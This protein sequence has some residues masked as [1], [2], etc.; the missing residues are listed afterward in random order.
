ML[1]NGCRGTF[2]PGLPAGEPQVAEL[3]HRSRNAAAA[4]CLKRD[5]ARR[6]RAPTPR[7]SATLADERGVRGALGFLVPGGADDG[8]A[9]TTPLRPARCLI[10]TS[11]ASPETG[12][13]AAP[14]PR[15]MLRGEHSLCYA[16][17][18]PRMYSHGS[19][20]HRRDLSGG[21]TARYHVDI[22]A[23][24]LVATAMAASG[25]GNGQPRG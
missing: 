14:P 5:G 7:P 18:T 4:C 16:A 21:R 8:A 17:I 15:P 19:D 9:S 10:W 25:L 2:R 1:L 22:S 11:L 20:C 13:R 3:A 6:G 23:G 24:A 12:F